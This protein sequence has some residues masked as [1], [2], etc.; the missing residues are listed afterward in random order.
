MNINT[1]FLVTVALLGLHFGQPLP[2]VYCRMAR[3]PADSVISWKLEE[4]VRTKPN[5]LHIVGSPRM[6]ET[7]FGQSVYFDGVD[8]A[9]F[10]EEMPLDTLEAFTIEMIFYPDTAGPFEQRIV[11]IGEVFEDRM[12]LE[13]RAVDDQWYFDGFVSSAGNNKALIDEN[14]THPLGQWYHVAF[15]VSDSSLDTYVNGSH[16]LHEPFT[17]K[18][19]QTGKCAIGVRQNEVSW[20]KGIIHEIKITPG[21]LDPSAFIKL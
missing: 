8:D 2:D 6:V 5:G 15:V 21:Q 13:I 11:H 10:L 9:L 14:L 20:F 1:T 3:H 12:L 18:G 7:P 19:I 16:E 17:F 4:M